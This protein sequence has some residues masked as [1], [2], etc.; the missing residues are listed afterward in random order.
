[1]T[2]TLVVSGFYLFSILLYFDK[3]II[4]AFIAKKQIKRQNLFGNT[5][6]L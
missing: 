2:L 5:I 4:L 6:Y 3:K 1:M